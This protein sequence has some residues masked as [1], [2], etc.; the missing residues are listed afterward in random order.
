M[1]NEKKI[2]RTLI[3]G[4]NYN[5]LRQNGN[6]MEIIGTVTVPTVIRSM[7]EQKNVLTAKKFNESDVLVLTGSTQKQ[8]EMSEADFMKYATAVTDVSEETKDEQPTDENEQE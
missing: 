4:Y 3:V 7:K 8:Y 1:A 5:V 6:T 2:T